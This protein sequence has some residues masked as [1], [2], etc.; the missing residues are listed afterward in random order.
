[1]LPFLL[2]FTIAGH[3]FRLP[4]YGVLLAF[5]FSL[6]Y[7]TSIRRA[8]AL[9]EDPRHVENLFLVI[10]SASIVGSRLFHV[11]FE[12]PSYYFAHPEKILAVW[13]GGY[14]FYGAL[15]MGLFGIAV[16]VRVQKIDF[17][18]WADICTP[19]CTF[20][21]FI[22]RIG[23]FLAGCCWGKQCDLPW[24]VTF[25]NPESFTNLKNVPLHPSQ[26]YESFSAL[27]LWFYLEWRYK[28]QTYRGQIFL[29]AITVYA[30]IRFLI[31][32]S[33]GDEYRGY[34][35]NGLVSYSQLVSLSI[36]PFSV[37]A[38]F[39]YGKKNKPLPVAK[40]TKKKK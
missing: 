35:L 17:L 12:E 40:P 9:N 38:M 16:Y 37:F 18:G 10:I 14:T 31:E 3:H 29:H 5:S 1:M 36:I 2:D 13:E 7:F 15:L 27:L 28:R 34:V 8:K 25:T 23:C 24:A 32:Y 39:Y 19:A 22:G 33:R 20:G 30:V 11:L 6:A 4:S 21:L 26:L